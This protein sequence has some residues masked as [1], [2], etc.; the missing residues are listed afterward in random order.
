MSR[1]RTALLLGVW[2]TAGWATPAVL[3]QGSADK[4]RPRPKLTISKET[5]HVTEP[6]D[7]DG[8]VDFEAALNRRLSKGVTPRTNANVLLWQA[9]GP[10]PAGTPAPAEFF[11]RLG[12]ETPKREAS[13][14][15][16]A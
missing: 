11:R 15:D 13:F 6:L 2:L 1:L 5:T 9:L 10:A 7:A 16:L 8:W 3:G 14:V 4:E 12:M